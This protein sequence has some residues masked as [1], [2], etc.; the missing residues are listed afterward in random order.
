MKKPLTKKHP[1]PLH[2]K[3][4]GEI[5]DTRDVTKHNKDNLEQA[6]S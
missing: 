6:Y 2:N 4:L 5:R 1:I 3:S